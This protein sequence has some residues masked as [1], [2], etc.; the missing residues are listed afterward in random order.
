MRT[1]IPTLALPILAGALLV[2]RPAAE[3]TQAAQAQPAA[4]ASF[5]PV[6]FDSKLVQ[7]LRWRNVGP[8]RGGRVT[9]VSGVRT[10]L[11]T[12]YM[13]ATGGGV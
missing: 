11:C 1:P 2:P 12:F 13:G 7:D 5:A 4:R 6:S 9:A 8:T 3:P 10:Q